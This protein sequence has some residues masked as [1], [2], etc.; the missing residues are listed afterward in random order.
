M[1]KKLLAGSVLFALVL[2]AAGAGCKINLK[3]NLPLVNKNTNTSVVDEGTK[4]AVTESEVLA[5]PNGHWAVSATAST[6]YSSTATGD[7]SASKVI[8]KPDVLAYGDDVRAWAPAE[9]GKGLEWVETAYDG[10]YNATG[11]RV[12]ENSG[13]GA[14]TKI[15]LKDKATGSYHEVWSG[16]DDTVGLN[17]FA[18]NFTKTNYKTDTVKLTFDTSKVPDEWVEIDAVQLVGTK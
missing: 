7:W 16:N 2:L 12:R 9:K 18:I 17:C 6:T 4:I 5:E 14:L 1:Q 10:A 11:V 3:N 8:G 15:E 13:S